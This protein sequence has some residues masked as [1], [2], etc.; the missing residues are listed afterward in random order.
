MR[1]ANELLQEGYDRYPGQAFKVATIS[2]WVVVLNGKQHMEDIR[3]APE[4]VVSFRQAI[5][6]VM[7][8]KYTLGRRFDDDPYHVATVRSPMTRNLAYRFEDI[9]DEIVE[10][11]NDY[12]PVTEDWTP[13]AAYDIMAH[14]VCRTSNRYF[15][16]LPLCR[17]PGYRSLN[18]TFTRDAAISARIINCFP[19]FLKP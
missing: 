8:T 3:K 10:S 4:D 7:Q 11:F 2:R 6:E 17:D 15:V 12:I 19:K 14:I 18:E 16:G 9:R 13:V 1:H 5:A